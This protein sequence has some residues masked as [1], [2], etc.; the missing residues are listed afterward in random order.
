LPIF[1]NQLQK[2]LLSSLDHK[3]NLPVEDGAVVILR[4]NSSAKGI[5]NVGW[6]QK[7]NFPKYNFRVILHGNAGYLSSDELVP[8]NLYLHAFK[9]GSKNIFRRAF[10]KT[11][12]PLAYTYYFESYYKE[13]AHF[14]DCLKNDAEPSVSATDGLKT[15]EIIRDAYQKFERN[16]R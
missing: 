7:T 2:Y 6:Y 4:S 1:Q 15:I 12:H 10:G 14:F 3:L 9:E 16:Q 8:H 11:V 5:I 13:L